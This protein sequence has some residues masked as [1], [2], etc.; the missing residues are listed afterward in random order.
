LLQVAYTYQSQIN[1]G[2][3]NDPE[4]IQKGYGITNLSLGVRDSAGR[5]EVAGFVNNLFDKQYFYNIANSFGNQ[6][7][8][9]AVQGYVPR[10]FRRYGG[11]RASYNF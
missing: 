2:L 4:T 8:A 10:D 3:N 11:V 9:E 6:G 1:F 7:N 5:W